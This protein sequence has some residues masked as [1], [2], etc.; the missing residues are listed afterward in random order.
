MMS[1]LV[2]EKNL[3]HYNFV[4]EWIQQIN[5]EE[6]SDLKR[7]V[8]GFCCR[9]PM[10]G[11]KIEQI[12]SFSILSTKSFMANTQRYSFSASNEFIN[13]LE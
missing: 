9:H 2:A 8:V 13:K 11:R 12:S 4:E 10:N 3:F 5:A 7:M 1:L 6:Y